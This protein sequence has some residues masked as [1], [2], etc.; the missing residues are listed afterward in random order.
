MT[1][2]GAGLATVVRWLVERSAALD[3]APIDDIDPDLDLV[4][5]GL[6]DSMRLV[7]F[8]FVLGAATGTAIDIDELTVDRLRTLRQISKYYFTAPGTPAA[9]AGAT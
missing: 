5:T 8:V 6:I 2:S 4:D 7:E 9:D 3:P 1:R